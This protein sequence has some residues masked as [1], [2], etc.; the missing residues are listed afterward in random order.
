MSGVRRVVSGMDA[1]GKSIIVS[2]EIVEEVGVTVPLWREDGIV[3]FPRAGEMPPVSS[4]FPGPGGCRF[5]IMTFPP[6]GIEITSTPFAEIVAK[7]GSGIGD[8]M[9]PGG[10]GMHTTDTID[11]EVVLSGEI[12]LEV[13]DGV[14]VYLKAGDTFV[15]N[16]T[17]HRWFNRGDVPAVVAVVLVGGY[18]R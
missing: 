12:A 2:D 8:V 6:T 17:R 15:Q 13:D 18:P 7:V 11:F 14:T 16:G 4:F 3:S 9:E 10:N 1:T 5:I